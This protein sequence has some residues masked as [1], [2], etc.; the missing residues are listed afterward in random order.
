MSYIKFDKRQLTN[1]GFALRKEFVRTNRSGSYA[2]STVI[3]CNTRKYHGLLVVPQPNF[4]DENHVL[5]SSLDLTVVQHEASF[6]LGIHKYKGGEYNPKGHKYMREYITDPIPKIT[7]RVGGVVVSVESIFSEKN[8]SMF[9][10]YTLL[11]A[12]S[13]TTFKI[14]PF[15]AFRNIHDLTQANAQ[16]DTSYLG[17]N[18]GFRMQLYNRF[19]PLYIQFSKAVE[20]IHSPDWFHD[21]EYMKEKSRGYACHEDLLVPGEFEFNMKKGESIILQASIEEGDAST[22]AR[23][24]N[25]QLKKRVPRDSFKNNLINAAQQFLVEKNGKTEIA[26]GLPWYGSWGR[27]TFIS[28]PG[29]TLALNEEKKFI[30]I[31]DTWVEKLSDGF[32]PNKGNGDKIDYLS[33][34]TSLWFFWTLQKYIQFGGK[35]AF[36]WKKYAQTMLAV[37][38]AYRKGNPEYG[39]TMRPN[40]L[41]YA[42]KENVPLSWMDAILY[43]KAVTPRYGFT[44]EINA[45]WYNAIAFYLSLADKYDKRTNTEEWKRI[46]N[47]AGENFKAVFME[48]KHTYLADYVNGQKTSWKVR[49]NMLI[50]ASLP[51]SPLLDKTRKSVL[52][53]VK[54]ELFTPRGIRTLSPESSDYKSK[55]EGNIESRDKAFHNGTAWPWLLIPYADLLTYLYKNGAVAELQ[56]IV[57]RFEEEMTEHG[58]GSISELYNGDPPYEGKGGVSQAWS[59]SALLCLMYR[60]ENEQKYKA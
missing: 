10:R 26:A 5:L 25:Q 28:L 8:A 29:L 15:L 51:F 24:F 3:G 18:N 38:E 55:Y 49:P 22:F 43:G 14:K 54:Q 9:V 60:I 21:F 27:D 23:Q 11:E 19:T 31:L 16:A 40:G 34:D 12:T 2:S 50:A 59:V 47:F 37:L 13:K 30:N 46:L 45:L 6:N 44:V 52:D 48:I 36:V 7:Y 39:I 58:I 41:I 57:N 1:L 20:Y 32:F 53:V 33:A 35:A 17:V 56:M 4:G 42:E